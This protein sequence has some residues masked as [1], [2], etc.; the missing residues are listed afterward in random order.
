MIG[1]TLLRAMWRPRQFTFLFEELSKIGITKQEVLQQVTLA[2]EVR[3]FCN[4][5]FK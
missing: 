4:K 3:E 2:K 5:Q 1:S